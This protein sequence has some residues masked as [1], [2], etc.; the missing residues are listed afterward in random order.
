MVDEEEGAYSGKGRSRVMSLWVAEFF[1]LVAAHLF[2]PFFRTSFVGMV[3]R[4]NKNTDKGDN[5]REETYEELVRQ[6]ERNAKS[7]LMYWTVGDRVNAKRQAID[8]ATYSVFLVKKIE[9][10]NRG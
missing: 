3:K 1:C 6:V 4:I 8:A 10:A 2:S 7:S 5:W 9:E